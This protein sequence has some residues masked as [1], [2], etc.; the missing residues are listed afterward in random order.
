MDDGTQGLEPRS[1]PLTAKEH[2]LIEWLLRHGSTVPHLISQV[3]DLTVTATCGCGCPT[4]H[5]ELLAAPSDGRENII[6][7]FT[8]KADGEAVM[9][10]LF[11]TGGRLSTL[12]VFS[13][14]GGNK[15][16]GLPEIETL[17]PL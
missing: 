17:R 5:F 7:Q 13:L 11:E 15:P 14:A 9:V 8:G 10:G 2:D 16:F 4:I 12:E 1:R 6:A 3:D